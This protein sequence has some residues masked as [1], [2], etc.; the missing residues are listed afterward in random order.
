[1]YNPKFLEQR[2][3]ARK[4][5]ALDRKNRKAGI[6]VQ[7]YIREQKEMIGDKWVDGWV[8]N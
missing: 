5:R 3:K 2:H 8:A 4:R 6:G 7:R 1:M